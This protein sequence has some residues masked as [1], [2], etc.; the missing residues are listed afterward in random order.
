MHG[1]KCVNKSQIS[2]LEN[3]ANS[4]TIETIMKVFNA[5]KTEFQFNVKVNDKQMQIV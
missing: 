1:K 3:H 5:L 2:K 4:T